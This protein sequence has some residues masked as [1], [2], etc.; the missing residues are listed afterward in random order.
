MPVKTESGYSYYLLFVTH[1]DCRNRHS[2]S[3]N[4]IEPSG[5]V[6]GARS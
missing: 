6:W 3:T 4:L 2:M 1:A 5:I